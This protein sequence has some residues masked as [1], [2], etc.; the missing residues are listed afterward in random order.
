MHL[1]RF[2]S[3]RL[4]PRDPIGRQ[5]AAGV[6]RERPLLGFYF[7]LNLQGG[8]SRESVAQFLSISR[9]RLE[10]LAGAGQKAGDNRAGEGSLAAGHPAVGATKSHGN[11]AA[12]V[13][14]GAVT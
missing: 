14:G 5:S 1:H 4:S 7:P 3:F 2:T 6:P 10:L 8:V 9:N 12:S 11:A 13:A